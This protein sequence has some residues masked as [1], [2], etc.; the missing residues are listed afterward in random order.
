MNRCSTCKWWGFEEVKWV[1]NAPEGYRKCANP[2]LG[3]YA[4]YIDDDKPNHNADNT[5]DD[6]L[7]SAWQEMGETITGPNFGCVH[8]E[9]KT[10]H[11]G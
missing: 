1:N 8:W 6:A 2:K 5:R 11:D 10:H 3:D 9:E 7:I 4:Q